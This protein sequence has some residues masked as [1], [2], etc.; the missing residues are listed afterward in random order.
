MGKIQTL[1]ASLPG[2]SA[3]VLAL[4][5]ELTQG[6]MRTVASLPLPGREV[7]ILEGRDALWAVVRRSGKGGLAVRTAHLPGGATSIKRRRGDVGDALRLDIESAIGTQTVT[8]SSSAPDLAVLRITVSLR[9]AARLLVPFLPRDLY[10]LGEND[11]PLRAEG[12]VEAAQRGL[13]TGV[14]YFH[15]D[16]PAFGSV[17]YFQNFTALSGYFLSTKT[18]PDGAVGGEWP[19][20]GYLPPTPPQSGTPPTDP[21][22]QG[23]DTVLSDALLVFHDDAAC[24]EQ[25]SALRFVQMLGAA[26]RQLDLPATE[27]RDWV[28]RAD[29]TL[30]DLDTA[31]EATIRHYGHRYAHPY[32]NAEY[33]DIMVQMALV[34][35]LHDYSVWKNEPIALEAE[36]AAGLGKFHDAKLKTMR[37][38]LPNVGKD[39]D[40]NAVDSWYLYH[41]LLNLGRLAIEGDAQA[42]RLFMSSLDYAIKAAH[43]FSYAWPIQFKVDDFSIIVEARNDDGLG[44]TDVGGIY[45]YVMLQAYELTEDD[46]YLG[47]AR[48]AIDAA[49]DMRFELNYQ[50][51]LTA[52]GASACMRLWRITNEEYYLRQSYVYLASFFHNSAIWESQIEAARHYSN[53]LGVTCLHDAPYMAIYEC[54]DSFIAFERYLKDSGPDLDSSARMLISEY[55]KYALDRAW[56]YY[57]DA[58][59]AEILSPEVRN[60][61]ID[62]TLSFPLEDLYHDGQPAGQVGQ[63]IYGAGAALVFAGRAFHRVNGESFQMFCDHFLMASE[64][65]SERSLSFRLDG[66]DGCMARLSLVRRGRAQLPAFTVHT[67]EGD[68]VR[69]K[70]RTDDRVDYAIPANGRVTINWK[71]AKE[72]P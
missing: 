2:V 12:R 30:H 51:N 15:I 61:H 10:P 37:R 14:S 1:A 35:A 59:P 63:E 13:N 58:L 36:F 25:D 3:Q 47:E 57:P 60:G 41:P 43:H 4:R 20:I 68:R 44:Q 53:F 26:Y 70:H 39:K 24:D 42:K 34:T 46:R 6:A 50:A 72:K 29:R 28:A 45:A 38:Y 31:P 62:R 67:A 40:K 52:W 64:R 22:P 17:L 23:K 11:D 66:G 71:G 8:F 19:E 49:K 56:F 55:C 7:E 48:T 21:L 32:T 9:P 54:F 33:P 27:F 65:N 5:A 69:P 18:T 16:R